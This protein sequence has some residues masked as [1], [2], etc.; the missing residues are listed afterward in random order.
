MDEN[1]QE[2]KKNRK[3]FRAYGNKMWAFNEHELMRKRYASIA[4]FEINK[5]NRH[6]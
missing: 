4:D 1:D 5:I 6:Q 3:W 2:S